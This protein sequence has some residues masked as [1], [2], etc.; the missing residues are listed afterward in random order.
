ASAHILQE[1][2]STVNGLK[3][4]LCRYEQVVSVPGAPTA[5]TAAV[6]GTS[7]TLTWSPPSSTGDAAVTGYTYGRD[8]TDSQGT[9][10][11]SGVTGATTRA[12]TFNLLQPGATY[13]L[14]VAATNAAGT[15]PATSVT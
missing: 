15:G 6:T 12:A 10:P 4:T 9:G 3:S 7:A 1:G 8:G 11:W 2:S 14:T 13:H 5:V